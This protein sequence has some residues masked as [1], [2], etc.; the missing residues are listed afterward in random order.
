MRRR[1]R[2]VVALCSGLVALA[3]LG[4]IPAIPTPA[5][6]PAPDRAK[7]VSL[8]RPAVAVVKNGESTI[9]AQK[10]RATLIGPGINQPDPFPGYA[11]FVGWNSP[12]LVLCESAD[13]AA[14]NDE[15]GG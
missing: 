8:V 15:Y 12:V 10:C 5:A 14:S 4:V 13:E 3:C 11:G 2:I 9:R 7:P 6:E 1:E